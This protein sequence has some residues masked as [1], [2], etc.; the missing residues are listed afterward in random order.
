MPDI[1]PP[2]APLRTNVG[3][4]LAKPEATFNVDSVPAVGT[5][6][7]LVERIDFQ[8]QP[9]VLRRNPY[10]RSLSA[11]RYKIGRKEVMVTFEHELKGSGVAG[12]EAKFATL[13]RGCGLAATTIANTAN[14]VLGTPFFLCAEKN[15]TAAQGTTWAKT[16]AP[17]AGLGYGR[18]VVTCI[19]GGPSLT[20]KLRVSGNPADVDNTILASEEF[21]AAVYGSNPTTTFVAGGTSSAPTY[22]VGGVPQAGDIITAIVG[23]ISFHYELSGTDT[24]L[25]AATALAALIASD[26]RFTGTSATGAVINITFTGLADGVVITSGT[27]AVV[28]GASGASLT[29]TFSGSLVAGDQWYIDVLRPGLHFTPVSSGQQSLTIYIYR[30]GNFHRVTGC[31]GSVRIS[32]RAGEYLK[33][34]F[35]F[36]GQWNDA[37]EATF[38]TSG[39]VFECSDPY[40]WEKAQVS[41][42]AYSDMPVDNLTV[43]LNNTV[44][45]RPDASKPDGYNGYFISGRAVRA[46]IDPEAIGESKW[47]QWAHFAGSDVMTFHMRIGNGDANNSVYIMSNTAQISAMPY[48]DKNNL[49]YYNT[50]LEFSQEQDN[51]DDDIR[52]VFA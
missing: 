20:A 43:D 22:T 14:A 21:K 49:L 35:T 45:V 30:D 31:M 42:G 27:T 39:V 44:V 10:R 13:L 41:L 5:D 9:Q 36:H 16:T 51:G 1:T 17:T 50:S 15:S 11:Y 25:T 19:L 24:T 37:G 29:P 47:R 4:L 46:D 32:G 12:V 7:F 40:Q 3:L 8:V 38:P 6:A 48:T 26:A 18:Y 23:G 2:P 28:L 34:A 52:F 33:G